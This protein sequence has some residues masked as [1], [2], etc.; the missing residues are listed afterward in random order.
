MKELN[1]DKL[2][3]KI[4]PSRKEMGQESAAEIVNSIKELLAVKSEIN[5]IF[6]AAPS[7]N[8]WLQALVDSD[9]DWSRVHAF[10]MDEYIGLNKNAPQCFG[11]FLM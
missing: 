6:A 11:N 5:M 8:E 2:T 10:H 3:V 4:Y 1:I 9:V 7:Q